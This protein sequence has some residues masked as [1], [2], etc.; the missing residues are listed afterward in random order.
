MGYAGTLDPLAS[1]LL[2]LGVGK[3]TRV[4]EFIEHFPKC[5]EFV[6]RL[7]IE[8]DTY[9]SDGEV[10]QS[11]PVP[12]L[13]KSQLE[14]YLLPFIGDISQKPPVYSAIKI[15]GKRACDRVR[16][17]EDV[18][19]AER[20][21][22][23]ESIEVLEGQGERWNLRMHCSRGTYVR[24]IA[25]DLGKQIGCGAIAES[26]R[27]ISIGPFHVNNAI[28]EADDNLSAYIQPLML[29]LDG[30]PVHRLKSEAMVKLKHGAALGP[31]Y[32]TTIHTG[33]LS[34]AFPSDTS[35]K[36]PSDFS[37]DVPSNVDAIHSHENPEAL[38]NLK[39]WHVLQDENGQ[40]LALAQRDAL[41]QMQPK[42][43]L[44]D[45]E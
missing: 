15:K 11:A 16:R 41:G 20:P 34:T 1:G 28:S 43:V 13:S 7:G 26:I 38:F 39:A 24:S 5:Y 44:I 32:F 36:S 33:S 37:S 22:H 42:R 12:D 14:H 25:H 27:R 21:I 23:V 19:L 2:L 9:D 10:L 18:E 29:A 30:L 45:T 8:T 4:L 17:G 35:S 31:E 3:A 40:V 6:L